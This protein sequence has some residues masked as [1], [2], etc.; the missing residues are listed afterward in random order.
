MLASNTKFLNLFE[1][2]KYDNGFLIKYPSSKN[3]LEIAK[4]KENKKLIK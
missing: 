4:D 1:I 3:P 2:V